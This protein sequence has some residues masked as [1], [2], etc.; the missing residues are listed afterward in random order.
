[1]PGGAGERPYTQPMVSERGRVSFLLMVAALVAVAGV[2]TIGIHPHWSPDGR[3][4]NDALLVGFGLAGA[5]VALTRYRSTGDTHPLFVGAA[6]LVVVVQTVIFDQLW[7]LSD[8]A[9]P[10]EGLS[11][12]SLGWLIGWMI[13]AAG[14]VLA[15]PWW[16]RRGRKP[17]R[18]PLVL[19]SA[20]GALLIMDVILS[21]PRHSLPRV[22]NAELTGGGAFAHTSGFHWV[23]GGI[24]IVLL[25]I[26]A[27]REMKAGGDVR[28]T[29]PW[30]AAAWTLAA[31][32]QIVLL[33][34]PVS[35]RPIVVPAETLVVAAVFLALVAF[36]A[37]QR[38]E[39]SRARRASDRAQEVMGGR[40][41]IAAMISHEVRGPVSTI[42]G[43][44]GTAISHYDRLDDDE[45]REL[46]GLIEQESRRL[47]AT[48]TQAS[49]ALKVDAATVNYEIRAQP[50]DAAVREG[51]AAADVGTHP[52]VED[53][54]DGEVAMDRRWIIEAVRQLVDN[55]A[56]F[57]PPDSPIHVAARIDDGVA[58]IEV[59]DR[60]PGIPFERRDDVF[61]KYPNWRPDGYEQEAGSGLGLFLVRGIVAGHQGEVGIVDVPGGGTMLRVRI[62]RIP[63]IPMED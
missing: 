26:A 2:A 12:P 4:T 11:F 3:A 56:K 17:L 57:S 53:L 5:M 18:A 62:P 49:T 50:L 22:K 15:R 42:R 8:A 60:G 20:A 61:D 6:L 21:V 35:Y 55:A 34:H 29:H 44:A 46:L 39:A 23:M 10:W 40:A 14:L 51:I 9:S 32:G 37:P 43:L 45:R 63:R 36:L 24:V 41:E 19:G 38:S 48:V 31:A 47:L 27:W 58:T 33:A 13:A 1:M 25:A 28:S 30:L 54:A 59:V 7:I 16:D 52:V